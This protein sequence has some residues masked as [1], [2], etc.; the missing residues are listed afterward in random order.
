MTEWKCSSC[1][2]T[3]K[4]DT[5]PKECPYCKKVCNFT[6]VTCYIPECQEG[7]RDQRL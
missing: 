6:D 7:G 5:P 1:G 4:A 2:Y 3:V